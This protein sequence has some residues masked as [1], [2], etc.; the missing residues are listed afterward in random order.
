MLALAAGC[1]TAPAP[2]QSGPVFTE[3]FPDP[4]LLETP[5]GDFLAFATNT[6]TVHVQVAGSPDLLHWTLR[7]AGAA[8]GAPALDAMPEL[9][10]WVRPPAAGDADVWAPEVMRVA[11]RYVLYFAARSAV[12]RRPDGVLRQCVGAAV[13]EQPEGP[14]RPQARPLVCAQFPEGAIDASPYRE[15]RALHL[16]FKTDGNCCGLPSRIYAARLSA[17]G[18]ALAGPPVFTGETNDRPWEGKVVEAPTMVRRGGVRFLFY[19]GADYGGAGYAVGYAVCRT[20]EGPCTDAP[21]N[22]LLAS[23]P[24]GVRPPLIGPGHQAIIRVKGRDIMAFHGWNGLAVTPERARTLYLSRLR[25][26]GG[27]PVIDR[28]TETQVEPAPAAVA[29]TPTPQAPGAAGPAPP[30]ERPSREGPVGYGPR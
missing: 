5:G 24:P 11:G 26:P 17:D 10:A 6:D 21:S 28:P 22:P 3:G 25:W 7:R 8:P 14:Y 27:R 29:P 18:L 30:V 23:T 19:S 1:A 15:G 20:P 4:F 16:L 2:L 9:P 13:A 12:E